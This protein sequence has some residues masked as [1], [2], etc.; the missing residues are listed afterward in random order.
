MVFFSVVSL[1]QKFEMPFPASSKS[2]D[3]TMPVSQHDSQHF[4]QMKQYHQLYED[5]INFW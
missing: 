5:S 4:K 2:N 1:L 3:G